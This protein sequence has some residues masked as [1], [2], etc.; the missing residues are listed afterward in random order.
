MEYSFKAK[1]ALVAGDDATAFDLYAQ[2]AQKESQVATFYFDRPDL[3]P[4]RSVMVRS[5]AFLNLKAG[6]IEEA[7]Q[8][9][10][11]GLLNLTDSQIRQELND[12]LSILMT[13]KNVP[14]GDTSQ[15]SDYFNRLRQRSIFYTLE[16]KTKAF[17]SAVSAEMVLDFLHGL[18]DSIRAY[19]GSRFQRLAATMKQAPANLDAAMRQFEERA[20]P[21]FTSAGTGS[22]R[23]SLAN[24]FLQ[25]EGE[26]SGVTQLKADTLLHYHD[27]IFTCTLDDARIQQLRQEYHP[28]ELDRIYKPIARIH[29]TKT[30]YRV[31]YFDKDTFQKRYVPRMTVTQQKKLLARDE[32]SSASI[33]ILESSIIHARDLGPGRK[34]RKLIQ[35]QQLRSFSLSRSFTQLE[36]KDKRPIPLQKALIVEVNF[37]TDHGFH[38]AYPDLGIDHKDTDYFNGLDI[39]QKM[40]YDRIVSIVNAQVDPEKFTQWRAV[41]DQLISNPNSLRSIR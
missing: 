18:V 8:F 9:I 4:T 3:E 33:G 35:K 17:S 28:D 10:F 12:A 22:F 32:T 6:L 16:S 30:P 41:V 5:A 2:A 13:L 29:Y 40:I 38:I 23:F 7:Q 1:E 34:E 21:L 15:Y 27:N 37:D 19:A 26:E 14:T 31:G 20:I 11:W 25:R 39:V 24:D 36:P